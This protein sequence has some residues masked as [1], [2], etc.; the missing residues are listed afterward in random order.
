MT[1]TMQVLP[2]TPMIGAIIEGVDLRV[3]LAPGTVQAVREVLLAHGVVFF[4]GHPLSLDELEA[5][6][7]RFGTPIAEPYTVGGQGD[8][9]SKADFAAGKRGTASWHFDTPFIEEPPS[10][11]L[12]QAFSLP[13]VG[14]DTCWANMYGAYEALSKPLQSMLDGLTAVHSVYPAAVRLGMEPSRILEAVHPVVRV[15]P[16]TG[17]KALYVNETSTT[18]IVELQTAESSHLLS[19]LFEHVKS[20]DFSMRWRWKENDLA[21]WDNRAVQHYAV[22]DYET[23]RVMQRV[24][25]AGDR[26]RGPR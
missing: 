26:P 19:L 24:I 14:G 23:P 18:H 12:L 11:T 2:V 21:L 1:A 8:T 6:A 25:L 20:P 17:R 13:P 3:P 4:Q 10:L 5:F 7:L 9:V 16:E 22:P 15:H